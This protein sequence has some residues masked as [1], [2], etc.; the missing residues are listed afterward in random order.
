MIKLK[1][2]DDWEELWNDGQCILSDHKLDAED[3]LYALG[4]RF[5]IEEIESEEK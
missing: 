2:G 1:V 5:E 4:Y 3:V